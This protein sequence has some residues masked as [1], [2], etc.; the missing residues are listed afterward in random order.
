M[1][2]NLE[3]SLGLWLRDNTG[4]TVLAR[5]TT[6][7]TDATAGYAVGC[8]FMD[9]DAT[10]PGNQL[11]INQGTATSCSFR[12]LATVVGGVVTLAS[13]TAIT[14]AVHSGRTLLM[15]GTGSALTQTLP[16]ATGAGSTYTFVVGAVNT[17][18]HL[19]SCLSAGA[20]MYGNVWANSTGDSPDLGQPWPTAVDS[21]TITLNGTTTG[22]SAIGDQIIVRDIATN[23]YQV[24]GFTT[25]TSTEA[26]PFS[27]V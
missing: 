18:N 5:G 9:T 17:S 27:T 26:T 23:K 10:T 6:V 22:G 19:I 24:L 12:G 2:T 14:P 7:P 1:A 13:G 4:Y 25:C 15:T 8:I 16:A 20:V 21:N 11:F 3:D